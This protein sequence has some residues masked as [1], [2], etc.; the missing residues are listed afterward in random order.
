MIAQSPGGIP[1][2][3]LPAGG[4]SPADDQLGRDPLRP[5][6]NAE[7]QASFSR[8]STCMT[9]RRIPP[10]RAHASTASCLLR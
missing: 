10:S 3:G 5:P 4:S 2:P 9:W 8:F 6:D 1:T 7:D